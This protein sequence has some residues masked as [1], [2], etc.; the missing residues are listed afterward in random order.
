VGCPV[1]PAARVDAPEALA[2][3]VPGA[4]PSVPGEEPCPDVD[5]SGRI[6]RCPSDASVISYSRF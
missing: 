6:V 4:D 5:G 1:V 3:V 2:P